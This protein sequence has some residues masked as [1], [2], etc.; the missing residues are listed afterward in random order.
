[1]G[2]GRVR[3]AAKSATVINAGFKRF[4]VCGVA[5]VLF[6][7]V[8][9]ADSARTFA[10]P[11]MP[12]TEIWLDIPAQPLASALE[13]YTAATGTVAIYNGNLASGRMSYAV[14]GSLKLQKALSILLKGTGLAGEFTT[15]KAFVVVPAEERSVVEAPQA[16]AAAA[17]TQRGAAE[18]RYAA[19]VQQSVNDALCSRTVT[20]PG[21]YRA[22]M[23]IW[24]G[25]T[26]SLARV[27]LLGSTGDPSRDEAIPGI[28]D[29]VSIGEA[30]P[31][32]MGQPI[33]MVLL[34]RSSGGDVTCSQ[35]SGSRQHG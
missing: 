8:L 31:A 10:Q 29:R 33:T 20:E 12:A 23:R 27:Q 30:P 25:P 16:I 2:F 4:A 5:W 22:A 24:I 15:P 17:M 11:V 13:T 9:F 6:G 7:A 32:R 34:P 28:V 18:R 1:M 19:L 3:Q 35:S 14:K 21:T 26:G